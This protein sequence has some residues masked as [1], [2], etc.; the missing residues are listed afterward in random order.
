MAKKSK[1][2]PSIPAIYQGLNRDTTLTKCCLVEDIHGQFFAYK[3]AAENNIVVQAIAKKWD[4]FDK[5]AE[6]NEQTLLT[7]HANI[8]GAE[9]PKDQV[10]ILTAS[11]L[12]YALFSHIENEDA[13]KA[14]RTPTIGGR[15]STIGLAEYRRIS[16]GDGGLKTPQALASIRLLDRALKE[17]GVDSETGRF[18]SEAQLRIFV[19]ENAAE[20]KTRQDPWRIFQYYRPQ[21][22][23]AKLIS[24]T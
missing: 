16:E 15:K 6:E 20:L 8:F 17:R 12:W 18:I 1:N 11:Y 13:F 22:F 24:R 4:T 10:L 7:Y 14:I 5:F 9:P 3:T 23:G 2:L 21:M 19:E